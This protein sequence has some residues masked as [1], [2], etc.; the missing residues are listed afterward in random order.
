MPMYLPS[1]KC[2]KCQEDC[3]PDVHYCGKCGAPRIDKE[4]L[5]IDEFEEKLK[6]MKDERDIMMCGIEGWYRDITNATCYLCGEGSQYEWHHILM[7]RGE[8][9][10]KYLLLL[11]HD[12]H[13]YIHTVY[14]REK[15]NYRNDACELQKEVDRYLDAK[16]MIRIIDA[17]KSEKPA[18]KAKRGEE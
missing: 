6:K 10:E 1:L 14:N 12:C 16:L 18:A 5:I 13:V 7:P 2:D 17:I 15:F 3:R 11:C 4:R 8:M 9:R